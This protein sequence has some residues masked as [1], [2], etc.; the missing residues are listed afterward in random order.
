[1]LA[2]RVLGLAARFLIALGVVC[3]LLGAYLLYQGQ[4]FAPDTEKGTGTVVSYREVKDEN[5]TRWRPRIRFATPAGDIVTF[6]GQL[7]TR[8]QRY[9]LNSAIPVMYPRSAP[10]QARIATFTE[11]WLGPAAAGVLGFLAFVAGIFI[12]RQARGTSVHA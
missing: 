11:N 1:M 4:A 2:N 7:A 8:S 12:R 9:A 10:Q 3:M 6:E 5:E